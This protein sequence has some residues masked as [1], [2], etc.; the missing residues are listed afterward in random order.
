MP[1]QSQEVTASPTRGPFHGH[2]EGWPPQLTSCRSASSAFGYRPG[3]FPTAE[4]VFQRALSLPIHPGLTDDDN[5]LVIDA[6]QDSLTT[7]RR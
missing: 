5:L 6:V 4:A 2:S 7:F 3:A 1:G